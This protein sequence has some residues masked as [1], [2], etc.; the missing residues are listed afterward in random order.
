MSAY[1]RSILM[2]FPLPVGCKTGAHH[3]ADAGAAGAV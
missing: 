3:D 2:R 1:N